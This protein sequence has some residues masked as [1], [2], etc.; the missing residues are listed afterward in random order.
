MEKNIKPKKVEGLTVGMFPKSI[1][2]RINK[3]SV[4]IVL[5]KKAI[6]HIN[7]QHST[8]FAKLGLNTEL[9]VRFVIN[10]FNEVR[11]S[12]SQEMY[13]AVRAKSVSKMAIIRLNYK[14]VDY[15]RVYYVESAMPVRNS[16]LNNKELLWIGAHPND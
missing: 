10:N 3:M 8:E 7:E 13:L 5:T 1:A 11:I 2:K 12:K 9:F 16:Y 15:E 6:E 4:R 14:E